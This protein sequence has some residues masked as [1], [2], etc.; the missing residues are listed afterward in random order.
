[1][2]PGAPI[3]H[4]KFRTYQHLPPDAP[5]I[6][7]AVSHLGYKLGNV[8]D[9][10]RQAHHIFEHIFRTQWMHQGYL[11][12]H[13]T[14][15][16]LEDSGRV[17]VWSSNKMPFR[18]KELLSDC[19]LIPEEQILIHLLPIGGDF[20]GKGAVMDTPLCY[21]L[22]RLTRRPVKMVMSYTEELMAGNPRHPAII[23]LKTGVSRDG[24]L[25]ARQARAI[26]NSGAY[27]GFKPIPNVSIVGAAKAQGCYHIPHLKIDSYCVYTN[28]VPC[29]HTRAPGDPQLIFAVESQMD[30][31]AAEL[32]IDPLEFRTQNLL[33]DGDRLPQGTP[34]EQV[35]IRET[36][37][38]AAKAAG[39]G[40]RKSRPNIGRGIGIAHRHIGIGDANA[41]LELEEAGGILLTTTIPD[42]GT[43]AH[44]IMRQ[45][46][47]EILGMPLE[48][49]RVNIGNTDQFRTEAGAGASRVTHVAGRATLEAAQKLKDLL[50]QEASSVLGKA[51]GDLGLRGGRVE[52][53]G[54]PRSGLDLSEL[55]ARAGTRKEPL[56]AN[57]Y[58]NAEAHGTVTS[59]CAQV[60]E[61]EVDRE[62]GQVRVLKI[63]CAHDAGTV[64]NPLGHQGQIEGGIM[65]GVGF[66]LIEEIQGE[67]GRFSTLSL[68]D[69][70]LPNIKDIPELR[71]VVLTETG[72]PVPFGGKSVGEGTT[73]P[74]PGAIA[75]AVFDAVGVRIMETP[76]T[77]EKI[78]SALHHI[79]SVK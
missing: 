23:T 60:A 69:Y 15:V 54:N 53:R 28:C 59:F 39:W 55:A 64:I 9:G 56:K 71:T 24:K 18:L 58:L 74:V 26:F 65:H 11:E 32:G 25:I 45:I 50:L 10:F 36:L 48:R 35:R 34:L 4:E 68:G 57:C 37:E 52:V 61:V 42:T 27:G 70:K 78:Y 40:T 22:S 19:L 73:S 5:D 63:T 1:M 17:H 46:A 30:M 7:N 13:A 43:G 77:A 75:N 6:P 16:S 44:T 33:R 67:Q 76:I 62:T 29:G 38:A 14:A 21:H 8:E 49:V 72:G 31:M 47:C 12:P 79:H 66:S 3:L 51:S 41:E 2:Q 20:G